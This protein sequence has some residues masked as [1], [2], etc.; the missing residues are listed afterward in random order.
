MKQ[1]LSFSLLVTLV[2]AASTA[3]A[4]G[5]TL[6]LFAD[7]AGTQCNISDSVPGVLSVYVIH[8]PGSTGV[9]GSIFAAPKPDCMLGANWI[10]DSSPFNL[11]D[12]NSQTGGTLLYSMCLT[13]PTHVLTI[14][15]MASGLSGTDCPYSVAPAS[16]HGF[17]EVIN[18][19]GYTVGGTG[20]LTYV[21]STLPCEC[22]E[23][24]GPPELFVQPSSLYFDASQTRLSLWIENRGGGTLQWTVSSDQ[25]WLSVSPTV[26]V[27][28]EERAVWVSRSGLADGTYA[29]NVT[30]SGGGDH[31]IVPVTMVVAPT[32]QL[33]L[34]PDVLPFN[35]PST[36]KSFRIMNNGTGTLTWSMTADRPWISIAPP[37]AGSGNKTVSVQVAPPGPPGPEDGH[38]TVVSNGGTAS[39]LIRYVPELGEAGVIGVFEDPQA[40]RCNLFDPA[41]G[42]M[43]VYIV[44]VL[45]AGAAASQFAAPMPSCMTGATYL[46]ET[47]PFMVV[48]GNTQTGV[49]I[50]YRGCLG[51]TI[52]L[53]T[54]RYFV[55][56]MSQNCCEFPVVA[57]PHLPSGRIE[58]SSCDFE[59]VYAAGA[60]ATIN[61]TS[62]CACGS[63]RVE[64][65]TWG[66]IKAIYAPEGE[67]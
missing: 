66:Q 56:G 17:I 23:P 65:T 40:T 20:G 21:N 45:T 22:S 4:Q 16:G 39:V 58:V 43:T 1:V 9:S 59:V 2:L 52:H 64:E 13:E 41:P 24:S 5:G 33:W 32:P 44:H 27:N 54:V 48:L 18:C 49:A 34:D 6:C 11:T 15:Y 30:V 53:L 31:V 7:P 10:T 55:Q 47:S 57:D 46:G 14:Q 29:G 38:V 8:T 19:D 50:A 42:L 28:D 51:G 25:P 61:P 36:P 62:S 26:G 12:G 63:V 67:Q 35:S 37:L 60:H 3:F